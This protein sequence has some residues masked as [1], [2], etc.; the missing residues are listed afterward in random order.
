MTVVVILDPIKYISS[1]PCPKDTSLYQHSS[2]FKPFTVK[3][4]SDVK[5]ME[6][7][8]KNRVK[9]YFRKAQARYISHMC[10]GSPVK[11]FSPKFAHSIM[12]LT[13]S[14]LQLL[15]KFG[16]LS[17]TVRMFK[18]PVSVKTDGTIVTACTVV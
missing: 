10:G 6:M 13:S 11:Q 7:G 18:K 14:F 9:V 15:M 3:I 5:L 1:F 4:G 16:Y 2:S 8:K 12:F 17:I